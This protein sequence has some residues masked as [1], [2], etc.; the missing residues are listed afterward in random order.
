MKIVWES[1]SGHLQDLL[2]DMWTSDD[3]TDVTLVCDENK[4]I[5]AHKVILSACSLFLNSLIKEISNITTINLK[6]IK[7][8][9][10]RKV[11]EF[12]YLGQVDIDQ[13]DLQTFKIIAKKLEIDAIMK[14]FNLYDNISVTDTQQKDDTS[15]GAGDSSVNDERKASAQ[16]DTKALRFKC[17]SCGTKFLRRYEV[18]DH[19]HLIHEN[20]EPNDS[21]SKPVYSCGK[22]DYQSNSEL[23]RRRHYDSKH[24]QRKSCKMCDFKGQK[25]NDHIKVVHEGRTYNC[26]K[27]DYFATHK[28]KLKSHVH[29]RHNREKDLKLHDKKA[30]K[31]A[32]LSC[33]IC[34]FKTAYQSQLSR[35][36][37]IS[38]EIHKNLQKEIMTVD[39]DITPRV[40][41]N[42]WN[43][44]NGLRPILP[45][46][47]LQP[48]S[49]ENIIKREPNLENNI[50]INSVVI[51]EWDFKSVDLQPFVLPHHNLSS[52]VSSEAPIKN[53]RNPFK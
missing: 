34:T 53:I 46:M 38:H 30:H 49:M 8:K 27:C 14:K 15:E 37:Q 6:G 22:C 42:T 21:D 28:H 5:R 20:S 25:L 7:E 51:E 45:K 16:A 29:K 52:P 26:D 48:I 12:L 31:K 4:E 41:D 1:Y 50:K 2:H 23:K 24:R 13:D 39:G 40:I 32:Q 17:N 35:H 47:N 9:E 18:E 3:L 36:I 43:I 11:L 19:Y 44:Q 10:I 33:S